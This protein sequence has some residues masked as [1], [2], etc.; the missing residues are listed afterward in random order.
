MLR[1]TIPTPSPPGRPVYARPTHLGIIKV[2]SWAR[3]WDL[4][5]VPTITAR[6]VTMTTARMVIEIADLNLFFP[7]RVS[8]PSYLL[9]LRQSFEIDC[10]D[11]HRL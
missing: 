7:S 10:R 6:T 5:P 11:P 8:S 4:R 9:A 2:Y 3:A 1:I